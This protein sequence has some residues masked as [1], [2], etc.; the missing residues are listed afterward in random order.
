MTRKK[1]ERDVLT[2][3]FNLIDAVV[4]LYLGRI[5]EPFVKVHE[6]FYSSLNV[7]LRRVL[8]DNDVPAWFTANWITYA[9]TLCVVPTLY[10]IANGWYVV[11][12]IICVAVDFGDFLDGVV[13]R[14]WSDVAN[15]NKNKKKSM[16]DES[17]SKD[18]K[19]RA[20]SPASSDDDSFGK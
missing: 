7:A 11:A 9:R 10:L 19:R 15:G 14:Y 18:D 20:A 2:S 8:D 4:E 6:K 3:V 17:D 16:S 1:G 5:I 13:A 12:S